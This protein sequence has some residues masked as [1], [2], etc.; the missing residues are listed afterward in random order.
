M[1]VDLRARFGQMCADEL[2]PILEQV[3]GTEATP[4]DTPAAAE[5]GRSAVNCHFYLPLWCHRRGLVRWQ[6]L[7]TEVE[8]PGFAGFYR[9]YPFVPPT[10]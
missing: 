7:A 2:R 10:A 9:Y 6:H 3:L 8:S 1:T 4:T 5:I